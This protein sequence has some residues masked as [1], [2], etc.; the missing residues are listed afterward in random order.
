MTTKLN[1][2]IV[3]IVDDNAENHEIIETFLE[4]LQITCDHA[5]DCIE[6]VTLCA[7]KR[8]SHYSLILMDINLPHIDGIET[9]QRLR[10][11]GV[12]SPIIA[13][14]AISKSDSR[15]ERC[16]ETFDAILHKPFS[17]QDLHHAI[18]PYIKSTQPVS[19]TS[20]TDNITLVQNSN[21]CDFAQGISNMGGSE[22]L[23]KKHAKNFVSNNFDLCT[24]LTEMINENQFQQTALICHSTKGLSGMLGFTALYN[25]IVNLEELMHTACD[26]LVNTAEI[27]AIL[28]LI[29]SDIRN[30]CQIQF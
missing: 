6:A 13:V 5:F 17:F 21:I 4:D 27:S 28:T 26:G 11:A 14:T 10:N 7:D 2:E 23:F 20:T 24:R 8:N 9:T 18:S 25:N 19:Q 30:I 15:N 16:T 12:T 22:R 3:L 29:D 1:K